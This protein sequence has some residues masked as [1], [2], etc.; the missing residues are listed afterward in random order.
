MDNI[1][2]KRLIN[3][4]EYRLKVKK[5]KVLSI[6]FLPNSFLLISTEFDNYKLSFTDKE[7]FNLNA[8]PEIESNDDIS[9]YLTTTP[10][11]QKPRLV[12]QVIEIYDK[13]GSELESIIT[14]GF[15]YHNKIICKKKKAR[16]FFV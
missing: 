16:L 13:S 10:K 11:D 9:T 3:Q 6:C 2:F 15:T 8:A 1:Q 4:I 14:N 5:E 7:L 12:A